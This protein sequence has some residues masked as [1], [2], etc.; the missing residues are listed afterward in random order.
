MLISVLCVKQV[1]LL[2]VPPFFSGVF[3]PSKVCCVSVR[4]ICCQTCGAFAIAGRLQKLIYPNN[5][6]LLGH[7][8]GDTEMA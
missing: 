3:F 1:A 2:S 7:W 5:Q 8:E 4:L 6:A